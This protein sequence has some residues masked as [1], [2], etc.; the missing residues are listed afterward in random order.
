MPIPIAALAVLLALAPPEDP[1]R[2]PDAVAPILGEDT[3][4]VLRVDLARWDDEA[5]AR[6]LLGGHFDDDKVGPIA[7][8][9]DARAVA[10]KRLGARELYLIAGPSDLGGLP[11]LAVPLPPTAD[12]PAIARA[13]QAPWPGVGYG[14]AGVIRGLAVAAPSPAALGRIRDAGPVAR[15][16]LLAALAAAGDGPVLR[17]ALAPARTLRRA[18]EESVPALPGSLGGGPTEGLTRGVLWAAL[19]VGAD[20]DPTFRAAFRASDPAD[21]PAL[22]GRFRAPGGPASPLR[23]R[24]EGDRVVLEA[25]LEVALAA[26]LGPALQVRQAADRAAS[27]QNLKQIGLAMHNYHSTYD[28]FPPAFTAD[29]DGKPLLSWRV[30]ILPFLNSKELYDQFHRDEAWDGPHNKLLIARMPAIYASPAQ[31]GPLTAEGKTTYLAPRGPATLLAGQEGVSIRG[32]PDGLSN[33]LFVVEAN[34]A[35]A[36]TWS[37]PDDWRAHPEPD[38]ALLFGHHPGGTEALLG[39]GAVKFVRSTVPPAIWKHLATRNGGEVIRPE[40][41]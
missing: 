22:L 8:I 2:P 6:K 21:A 36:V 10:L 33:T 24:V 38:L 17:V 39:D 28:A 1:P 23:A 27:V 35:A 37:R 30:L 34:D 13:L 7:R 26:V 16:D 11:A 15:P 25:P 9:L 40:D 12:G 41:Y 14:A 32:V 18:I 5:T 4:A 20:P 31:A 3:A 29:K 19:A